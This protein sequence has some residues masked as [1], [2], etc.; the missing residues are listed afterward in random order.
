MTTRRQEDAIREAIKYEEE[1]TGQRMT[2]SERE[3]TAQVLR[4][5]IESD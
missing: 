2:S 3:E 4:E 1:I 5:F